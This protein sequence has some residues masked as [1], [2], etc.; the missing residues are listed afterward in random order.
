MRSEKTW[1]SDTEAV[2]FG[3]QKTSLV[4]LHGNLNAQRDRDEVLTP[5]L[6]P[7]MNRNRPDLTFQRD[8]A[9][10]HIA[11]LLQS[12]LRDKYGCQERVLFFLYVL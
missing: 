12:V 3:G 10:P 11:R 5:R 4:V 2:A 9:R 7:F 1:M 8:N 6:I